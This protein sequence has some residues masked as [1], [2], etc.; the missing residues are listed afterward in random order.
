MAHMHRTRQHRAI[1]IFF[2][3]TLAPFEAAGRIG[4]SIMKRAIIVILAGALC[5][6]ASSKGG[7]FGE[8][9]NTPLRDFNVGQDDIPQLLLQAQAKPY[10]VPPD[11]SCAAL[12]ASVHALD[13]LLGPDL[14]VPRPEESN[15]DVVGEAA[16]GQIRGMAD[17]LIPFR[18]WVRKLSGAERR[19]RDVAA[20]I[21]GGMVRRAF[22]KGQSAAR[23]CP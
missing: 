20:A 4:S 9:N 19:E 14:D 18:T 6:C 5:A 10:M 1:S 13:A 22:L 7:R 12:L 23:A 21:L 2:N 8:A 17:G 11:T 3:S 15:A 16:V